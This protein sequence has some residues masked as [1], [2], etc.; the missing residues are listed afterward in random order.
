MNAAAA[1]VSSHRVPR[2]ILIAL[3]A[4][5]W[6]LSQIRVSAAEGV[7]SPDYYLAGIVSEL[8]H[9]WPTN[10]TITIACHGHSV[11]AGYFKTPV[12]DSLNAYPHL[13]YTALKERFPYAVI[14][15]IVTAKGGENSESGAKRFE[16]DVLTLKP[17][18]VT[19]D[20]SLNDR[21]LGL[22][23]AETAWRSMITNALAH[24]IKVLLLTPTPDRA[25]KENPKDE[26]ERHADQVRHLA[27]K[28]SVGLVDSYAAFQAAV[29]SGTRLED[30]MAQS[31]HPNRRGH[32]LVAIELLRWFQVMQ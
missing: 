8:Q 19:I 13:L 29:K 14:N 28:Y 17:D 4:C 24:E 27:A 16:Q 32:E 10:R 22:E 18:L 21:S 2:G 25:A 3:F 7:A 20:Y 30:L 26:L 31:N 11:P 5:I 6:L 1:V 12:V 23:R 9:Q 15:V